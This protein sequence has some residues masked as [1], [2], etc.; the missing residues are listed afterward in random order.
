MSNLTFVGL[1]LFV[2][3]IYC[4]VWG[5]QRDVAKK[6][7]APTDGQIGY[8]VLESAEYSNRKKPVYILTFEKDEEERTVKP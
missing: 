1:L 2:A 7:N 5:I 8:T 6:L 4:I 3:G